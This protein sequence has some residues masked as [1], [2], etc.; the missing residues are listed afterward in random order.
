MESKGSIH[1]LH[2]EVSIK[3]ALCV[4]QRELWQGDSEYSLDWVIP[5]DPTVFLH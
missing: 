3:H 1:S 2:Q 5:K 4:M